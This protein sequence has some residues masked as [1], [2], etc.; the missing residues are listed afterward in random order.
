LEIAAAVLG[1]LGHLEQTV[2]AAESCTGG[3]VSSALT[4][5]P[6]ASQSF[7][8][9]VVAY[10]N[11]LKESLLAVPASMLV[12]HGAVSDT[13]ARAMAEGVKARLGTTWGLG[14]TGIAGPD[15]GSP[16][17]PVGLVFWAVA[18]PDGVSSQHK[19]FAGDRSAVRQNSVMAVLE[20]LSRR[21]AENR[22]R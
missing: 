14:I 17:K 2:A 12:A 9:G 11:Q 18:G 13:V 4:E 1:E 22:A 7:V 8:G 19:R 5:V 3:L 16:G 10:S 20:M 6:G 15:G 21:L